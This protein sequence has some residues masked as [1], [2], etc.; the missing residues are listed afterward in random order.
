M[1]SGTL[2]WLR[3]RRRFRSCRGYRKGIR[4]S[5]R[6]GGRGSCWSERRCASAAVELLGGIAAVVH[7]CRRRRCRRC[8]FCQTYRDYRGAENVGFAGDA[9]ADW[10]GDVT[11][12]GDKGDTDRRGG[13]A[14]EAGLLSGFAAFAAAAAAGDG[15]HERR[16]A[17]VFAE[18]DGG[19]YYT[20]RVKMAANNG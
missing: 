8:R 20:G 2:G 15:G 6:L 17:V 4:Q 14:A 18:E 7:C 13:V 3:R 10:G 12:V 5:C 11:L 19:E 16:G 1:W 9:E